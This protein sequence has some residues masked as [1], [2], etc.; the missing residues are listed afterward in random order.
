MA[1]TIKKL[2]SGGHVISHIVDRISGGSNKDNNN[3]TSETTLDVLKYYLK[4]GKRAKNNIIY[5]IDDN[6]QIIF[7]R[8]TGLN[9]HPISS[10]GYTKD[11]DHYNVEIRQENG[12]T[13]GRIIL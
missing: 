5:Q 9:A 8:D 10:H 2:I 4:N 12:N 13:N 1:P 11:Q 7:R 3:K 6:T